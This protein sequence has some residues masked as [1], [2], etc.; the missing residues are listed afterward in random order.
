VKELRAFAYWIG[1]AILLLVLAIWFIASCAGAYGALF[2]FWP[3]ISVCF[4]SVWAIWRVTG[5]GAGA[6]GVT[7]QR[8]VG[9]TRKRLLCH[10]YLPHGRR[11]LATTD[12]SFSLE[13]AMPLRYEAA[14]AILWAPFFLQ[15]PLLVAAA[16]VQL[17]GQEEPRVVIAWSWLAIGVMLLAGLVMSAVA[18]VSYAARQFVAPGTIGR[19]LRIP[20]FGL[21]L[22]TTHRDVIAVE[23]RRGLELPDHTAIHHVR[24]VRTSGESVDV[25]FGEL[26]P[27]GTQPSDELFAL[28]TLLAR[29]ARVPLRQTNA[30][31]TELGTRVSTT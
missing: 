8:S 12:P 14:N 11:V 31:T 1:R 17:A 10:S 3:V 5:H 9:P 30:T 4:L 29:A 21:T 28:A 7:L 20:L 24:F 22:I 15:G 23:I 16:L 19:R 6:S 18:F 26:K 25:A 13:L 2:V 27:V